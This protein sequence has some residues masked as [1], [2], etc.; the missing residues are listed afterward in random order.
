MTKFTGRIYSPNITTTQYVHQTLPSPLTLHSLKQ[1]KVSQG[2]TQYS[3]IVWLTEVLHKTLAI[4]QTEWKIPKPDA[5]SGKG[6]VG[7]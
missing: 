3:I 4:S 5:C 1:G 6:P 2:N 7:S